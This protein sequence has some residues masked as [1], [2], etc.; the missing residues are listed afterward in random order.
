MYHVSAVFERLGQKRLLKVNNQEKIWLVVSQIPQGKVASYGQVAKLAQLP[1][2]AR[3]V[4]ATMKKL[5]K[6]SKLPWYR[7]ANSAGKISFPVGS[8]EYLKQKSLLEAE[9]IVFVNG[10]FS[11]S[12]FGWLYSEE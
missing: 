2:Y 1:G 10:K 6:D 9:G 7:V 12:R 5:P 8:S 11:R 3:F 4:G